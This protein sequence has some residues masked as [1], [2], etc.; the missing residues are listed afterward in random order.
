M[1]LHQDFVL[2]ALVNNA[3]QHENHKHADSEWD[4]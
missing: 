2:A 3:A 4:S 1:K